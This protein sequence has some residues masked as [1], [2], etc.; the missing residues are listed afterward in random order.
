MKKI[1][2]ITVSIIFTLTLKAEEYGVLTVSYESNSE[3][4]TISKGDYIQTLSS[5]TKDSANGVAEFKYRADSNSSWI[6]YPLFVTPDFEGLKRY[7]LEGQYQLQ[8]SSRYSGHFAEMSYK[9]VRANEFTYTNSNIINVG[10]GNGDKTLVI[11]T[12]NDLSNWNQIFSSAVNQD[13]QLF[14][15]RLAE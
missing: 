11:E 12:S 6:T 3:I 5:H 7:F 14:R 9:I 13:Y 4:L 1:Y 8:Y 10:A 2:L 15:I